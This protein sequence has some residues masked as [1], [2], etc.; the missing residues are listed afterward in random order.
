VVGW[1]A[2][3]LSVGP[4]VMTWAVPT[5]ELLEPGENS[6][7]ERYRSWPIT[8][9]LAGLGLAGWLWHVRL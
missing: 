5:L 4:L 7:V 8:A 9:A 1:R 6:R 3:L 2:P